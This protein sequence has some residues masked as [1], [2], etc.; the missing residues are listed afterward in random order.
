LA[1]APLQGP[2]RYYELVRLCASHRYSHPGGLDHPS[3]S[4]STTRVPTAPP[5]NRS[6]VSR[7]QILLFHARACNE[8]TPPLHRTPPGPQAGRSLVSVTPD[9]RDLFP[10]NAVVPGFDA[11][12]NFYGASA[13]VYTC[14]SFRRVPDPLIADLFPS[15]F[16]PRLL[17][18]M[19]LGRF[20]ISA[21]TANPEDLPPSLAQH[22]SYWRLSTSS[23]RSF[24]DTHSAE[25]F[26]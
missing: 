6:P 20:G 3:F 17:T 18:D 5:C 15:R 16:P 10:G 25:S 9:G 26:F 13:V 1:P 22:G 2:H 24:Q 21:C 14:S 12:M 8:L 7:R 11:I 19:T 4:L 23:S